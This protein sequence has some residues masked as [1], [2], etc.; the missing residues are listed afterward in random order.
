MKLIKG[1]KDN[2]DSKNIDSPADIDVIPL[3]SK[4]SKLAWL[5]L[6]SNTI[7]S[8]KIPIVTVVP[9]SSER[10][11]HKITTFYSLSGMAGEILEKSSRFKTMAEI[12]RAADYIGMQILY[13]KFTD[14]QNMTGNEYGYGF[15]E[16]LKRNETFYQRTQLII[17][18]SRSLPIYDIKSDTPFRSTTIPFFSKPSIE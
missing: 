13:K 7:N 12:R 4:Q 1:D 8:E 18:F 2:E 11:E 5:D 16:H 15:Y 14:K 10:R 17:V 9:K 6:F 3:K